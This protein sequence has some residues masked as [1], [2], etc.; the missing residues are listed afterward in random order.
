LQ[1]QILSGDPTFTDPIYD[2]D[3]KAKIDEIVSCSMSQLA[4]EDSLI[5]NDSEMSVIYNVSSQC[6][7][8]I[9]IDAQF[10]SSIYAIN[11]LYDNLMDQSM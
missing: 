5:F 8:S 1:N 10:F 9:K 4:K 7:N 6:A 3:S 2:A 11:D